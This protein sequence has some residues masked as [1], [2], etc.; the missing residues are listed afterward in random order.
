MPATGCTGRRADDLPGCGAP[1]INIVTE[2]DRRERLWGWLGPLAVAALALGVRLWHLERPRTLSFDETYYA[3]NAWSMLRPGY[4]QDYRRGG[5]P[6]HRRRQPQRPVRRRPADPG[7]P[8]GGGQVADRPRRGGVRDGLVR[9]AHQRRGRRRADGAGAGP[10]GATPDR[11]DRPRLPGRAPAGARRRPPRD[12]PA[13]PARRLPDVLDRLR[14]G[15]P[16]RRPRLDRRPGSTD[17]SRCS[18]RGSCSPASASAWP[19]A[20]SGAGSTCSPCSASPWSCGRSSLGDDHRRTVVGRH[21]TIRR[22]AFIT[23]GHR[24][25][26]SRPS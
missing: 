25:W 11:L 5:R 7:R 24:G 6:A 18:G 10:A 23:L 20:P 17:S 4:A 13:G 14:G 15:L 16:G 2:T 19:A 3:K 9:L 21:V 8:P 26:A 12:V 1:T 22:R